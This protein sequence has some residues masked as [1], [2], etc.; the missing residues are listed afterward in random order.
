M[1][2]ALHVS[3]CQWLTNTFSPSLYSKKGHPIAL[4]LKIV[5]P[6]SYILTNLSLKKLRQRF[7][8][9]PWLL[10]SINT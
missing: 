5:I 2:A 8:L 9:N 1:P 6:F 10:H 4:S 7:F 3:P